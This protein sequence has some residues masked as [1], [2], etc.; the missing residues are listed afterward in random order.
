ML[1]DAH[2]ENHICDMREMKNPLVSVVISCFN[3]GRYIEECVESVLNQSFKNF[4]IIIIDD[5]STDNSESII[6][7]YKKHETIRCFWQ[8][9]RGQA[10]AKNRGIFE[11]KGE[12][13]AFLDADDV[14]LSNKL[15]K[16]LILFKDVKVGVVYSTARFLNT[17]GEELFLKSG[18]GYFKP[19][20]GFV[21]EYLIFDNFIYFS[22]SIVRKECFAN[23][24][25]FDEQ[26]KMGIDWDLW[27]RISKYY[28]FDYVDDPLIYYRIGHLGQMS[29][30]VSDRFNAADK[31][32]K[33][34]FEDN[35]VNM[36][37]RLIRK[38]LSY[39]YC[40][41]GDY[42]INKIYNDSMSYYIKALKCWPLSFR[43]Y[44]GII[45][46]VYMKYRHR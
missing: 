42:Y 43:V 37:D 36:T 9:N 5:G 16:Q 28:K 1:T 25:Y 3:Y 23:V 46:N 35:E 22:S 19:R 20:R 17:N 8:H 40:N 30:N 12:F 4:E 44:I 2:I 34:Y 10:N 14:W 15:E 45:K 7:K 13:I 26:I 31:I 33:K 11:S 41:R 39:S 18:K 21:G 27:L 29:K 6:N 24:G 38:A 32:M